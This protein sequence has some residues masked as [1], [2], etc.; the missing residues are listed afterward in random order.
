[1]E[2]TLTINGTY[3]LL[4]HNARMADPV[5]P[6]VLAKAKISSKQRKTPAEHGELA[7]LDFLGGLYSDPDI[8]PYLPGDNIQRCLLDASRI[9]KL[10][11]KFQRGVFVT[12]DVNPLAYDGPRKPEEL[13]ARED[14]R[15][16]RSVKIGKAR[17]MNCRPIFRTWRTEATGWCDEGQI[18]TDQLK[19]IITN[20]GLYVGL[21]DWRPRYGRFTA[22]LTAV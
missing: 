15:F 2:F 9:N 6:I 22:S 12:S 16:R 10:G 17:I 13:W 19:M 1:M 14:F 21:G 8:G 11:P 18:S 5:D 20:A 3:P 4:M 7:H